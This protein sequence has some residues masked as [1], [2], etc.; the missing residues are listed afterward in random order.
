MRTRW[1]RRVTSTH[2]VSL[3]GALFG[4]AAPV[5]THCM[6]RITTCLSS[7]YREI[8]ILSRP[9]MLPCSLGGYV[10]ST[11]EYAIYSFNSYT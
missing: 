9:S 4:S 10:Y 8:C 11:D 3:I 2:D 6:P 5:Y 7:V 1:A